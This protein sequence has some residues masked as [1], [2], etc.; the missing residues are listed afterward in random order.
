M[1]LKK[2]EVRDV[3]APMTEFPLVTLLQSIIAGKKYSDL[4][5]GIIFFF[6]LKVPI[7]WEHIKTSTLKSLKIKRHGKYGV[8]ANYLKIRKI[9]LKLSL[10]IFL[11]YELGYR[12]TK[13]GL[14]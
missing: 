12:H 9:L 11:L 10:F 8:K 7:F 4:Q 3:K 6:M 1:R 14:G 5:S 2:N 13:L